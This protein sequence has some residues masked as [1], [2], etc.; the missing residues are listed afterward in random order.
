MDANVLEGGET[1]E[2]LDIDVDEF[3]G[4]LAFVAPYRLGRLERLEAVEPEALSDTA[5]SRGGDADLGGNLRA[6]PTLSA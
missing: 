1:A 5:D 2:L 6:A 3:A 4:V